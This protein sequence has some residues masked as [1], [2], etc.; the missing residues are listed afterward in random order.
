MSDIDFDELDKA[1]SSLAGNNKTN[2]VPGVAAKPVT[3]QPQKHGG[4]LIDVVHPSSFSTT[5]SPNTNPPKPKKTLTPF[6]PNITPSPQTTPKVQSEPDDGQEDFSNSDA[7][8]SDWPDPLD[9]APSSPSIDQPQPPTSP[10]ISGT[11]V[12]KRPLGAIPDKKDSEPDKAKANQPDNS[13]DEG[14]Q[15]STTTE[16]IDETHRPEFG[17]ELAKIES[18]ETAQSAA[19][20]EAPISN[21]DAETPPFSKTDDEISLPTKPEKEPNSLSKPNEKPTTPSTAAPISGLLASSV[22]SIPQQYKKTPLTPEPHNDQPL[23]NA[24]HY[25]QSSSPPG[26]SSHHSSGHT[27]IW[28]W[29][30]IIIGLLLLGAVLGTVV[31]V[32]VTGQSL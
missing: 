5:S 25:D 13:F 7:Q 17:D 18:D 1:V 15:H 31:F 4:S 14:Q 29:V 21:F 26:A 24:E 28:Q 6:H 27:T 8:P 22:V 30:L 23:F 12:E 16:G 10:F 32:L 20:D 11:K 3:S 19:R 9:A 2:E